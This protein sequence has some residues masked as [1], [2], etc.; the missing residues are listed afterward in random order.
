VVHEVL[1]MKTRSRSANA[2]IQLYNNIMASYANKR[3]RPEEHQVGDLVMLSTKFFKPPS[4]SSRARKLAPKFAGPYKVIQRVSP[5]AYKL[6]LPQ[7]ANAHPAFH[8]SLLKVYK[9]DSTGERVSQVPEPISVDGQV[10]YIV[11]AVLNERVRRGK[12]EYL[13]HWAGYHTN[14]S[15]WE[16]VANVLGSEA[17]V[18]YQQSSGRGGVL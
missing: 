13:V 18:S 11:D 5:V 14:D 8:S 2:S 10:E 12:M 16:P 17:L 1:S 4:D 6:E 7:G 3:R 15:T 9:I